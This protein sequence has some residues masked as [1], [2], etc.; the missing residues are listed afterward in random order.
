MKEV[1]V[2]GCLSGSVRVRQEEERQEESEQRPASQVPGDAMPEG[3]AEMPKGGRRD[4]LDQDPFGAH[5]LDRIPNEES[6][7]VVRMP[8]I[9]RRQDDDL[10]RSLRAKTIGAA[11]TSVANVKK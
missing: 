7:D 1:C 8:R 5:G 9:G 3:D 4:D 6:R 10:Q 11:S 2:P